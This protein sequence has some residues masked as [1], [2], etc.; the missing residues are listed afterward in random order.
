MA[1]F[2]SKNSGLWDAE[3]QTTWNEAGHPGITDDVT[4]QN[5]HTVTLDSAAACYKL[6][7]NSGGVLTDATNNVGL[8]VDYTVDVAGTLTCG[9]A[10][11]SFGSGRFLMLSTLE[12]KA[13]G[14]FNGGSG[15]HTVGSIESVTATSTLN[16][17]SGNCTI[18]GTDGGVKMTI[19][20]NSTFAHNNGTIILTYPGHMSVDTHSLYN[21]TQNQT[22]DTHL[23]KAL[24]LANN[25][26]V[27]SGT[28][29]TDNDGG[30]SFNLV[31]EGTTIITS[32]LDCKASVLIDLN[33]NLTINGILVSTSGNL[34]FSGMTWINNGTFTHNSGTVIFDGA[35][36]TI[37]GSNTWHHFTKS[38]TT[39]RTLTINN[40][41]T[42]TFEKNL[43]L[44]GVSGQLLSILSDSAGNAFNFTMTAAAVKTSLTYLSVK[45]SD[46]SASAAAHKPIAPTNS[47]DVSGNTDWFAGGGGGSASLLLCV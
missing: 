17:T 10:A 13:G 18:D 27:T 8:T 15:N 3:G 11:M 33:D 47:T 32:Q 16:M 14:V 38:V 4:I 42:Q 30:A 39:A 29:E 6:I 40:L 41:S 21:L 28:F 12:I 9:S 44:N 45:D 37:N 23:D 31:V 26:V 24:N 1:I 20:S 2:T 34:N 36:Q 5:G 25:L 22:G 7:I 35:S 19:S 46:A 43:T